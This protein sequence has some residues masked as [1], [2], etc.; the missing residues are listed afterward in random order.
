MKKYQNI[1]KSRTPFFIVSIF[2]TCNLIIKLLSKRHKLTKEYDFN[3]PFFIIG[4]GRSGNTLLRSL[5]VA[6]EQV[7]IPP[8][9]YV[10]PRIYRRYKMLSFLNWDILSSIII[11]EFEAYK[12]F[13]TWEVNLYKAHQKSRNFRKE[14]KSLAHILNAVYLTYIEAEGLNTKRWG[15]KTPINTIFIDKIAKIFPKAQYIHIVRDPRDVVCS[16]VK[17]NLYDNYLEA[18]RFWELANLKAEALKK[19]IP[20]SNFLQLKYEDLV[21]NPEQELKRV[22]FFLNLEYT[23]KMLLFWQNKDSLGDV[24]YNEHHNNI[25][26][27]INSTSIG[28]WKGKLTKDEVTLI[29]SKAYSLMKKYNYS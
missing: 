22:C 14:E 17:A 6:G 11:S 4:S 5:L 20:A 23:P 26:N 15:D 3:H 10:L 16:Y 27:P 24:K 25:G 19:M 13:Y 12:E 2:D 1:I 8:E 29:E 9:S 21:T 7:S 18:L 28:K